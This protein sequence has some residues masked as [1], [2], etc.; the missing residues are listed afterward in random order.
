[1][2]GPAAEPVKPAVGKVPPESEAGFFS[3]LL[4][5]WVLPFIR[6]AWNDVQDGSFS[7]KSLP[8][9]PKEEA[10]KHNIAHL[11]KLWEQ[12]VKTKGANASL[13][14]AC[15]KLMGNTLLLC[16]AIM[17]CQAL[18][19]MSGPLLVGELIKAIQGQASVGVG[20]LMC[21]LLTL[22]TA[23]ASILQQGSWHMCSRSARQCWLALS[24]LIFEKPAL[25]SSAGRSDLTE[26]E[27]VNNMAV[28][29]QQVLQFM[30]FFAVFASAPMYLLVPTVIIPV[31]LGWPYFVGLSISAATSVA[32]DRIAI[33]VK[34]AQA[35]K[36]VAADK[37]NA[38]LNE[39]FQGIRTVKLNGWESLMEE[40]IEKERDAEMVALR[41]FHVWQSVQQAV[42]FGMPT[43]AVVVT[44]MLHAAQGGSFDA[45]TVFICVGLYEFLTLGTSIIPH[46]LNMLRQLRQNMQRMQKLLHKPDDFEPCNGHGL[47]PGTVV[48]EDA[49]FRWSAGKPGEAPTL[50]GM[51]LRVEPGEM[52][53]I[54]GRVGSGKSTWAG[55]LLGLVSRTRGST[56]VSGTVAYVTQ[57]AQIMND[58][59]RENI[60][61]GMPFD[62]DWYDRVIEACALGDDLKQCVA[63]DATEIG[64]RGITISG[65]QK[66]RIA[67][68]RA[69]YS[70]ADVMVFD[71]PLSAMDAHIGKVVFDRCFRTLLAGKTRVFFTNQLHFCAYCS[72]VVMLEDGVI[73]E[74]GPY[75]EL[76]SKSPKG[77]FGIFLESVVGGAT[78]EEGGDAPEAEAVAK[79]E[80]AKSAPEPTRPAK[81]ADDTPKEKGKDGKTMSV[82]KKIKGRIGVK[83]WMQIARAS[84]AA[85]LGGTLLIFCVIAPVAQYSVNIILAMWTDSLT[86]D[87]VVDPDAGAFE[88]PGPSIAYVG[89]AF[90]FGLILFVRGVLCVF[91]FLKSSRALH[92][93]MLAATV[94]QTM[95]WFDTTPVGRVLARFGNDVMFMDI[96]LPMLFQMWSLLF[97]R[98]IV[99]VVVA[100]ITAPPALLLSGFILLAAKVIYRYYGSLALELQ[101]VQMIALSPMLAAQSSFLSALDSVRCFGRVEIFVERFYAMQTNFIQT[102]YWSFT[103]DRAIQCIFTTMGVSV[104]FGATGC[105]LLFLSVYDTPLSGLVTPG[106]SGAIL[107]FCSILAFQAPVTLFMTARVEAM[108]ASVQRVAEYRDQP[109]E[110]SKQAIKEDVPASWPS[111]G[112]LSLDSVDMRYQESLPLALKCVSFDVAPGEKVGIVGRTGS[113]KSSIILTCFRMVDCCGGTLSIDGRD[114]SRVRLQELR[115]RLGVIPQDSWLFSGTIRQNLDMYGR[116]SDE[117][118]WNVLKIVQ[119]ESAAKAWPSG[120][121]HEVKEK[122]DNLSKGTAQL[123]CLARVLLKRPKLLFMDEAT[124]SVDAETDKLVQETIRKDGVLPHDCAI[125]TIAHRLHSVIDYDRIVVLAEGRVLEDAHP[126]ELLANDDGAF[127]KL[128]ESTDKA[129]SRELRRRS[130]VS[131]AAKSPKA[132]LQLPGATFEENE[133]VAK[134]PAKGLPVAAATPS[135]A[136]TKAAPSSKE[137]GCFVPTG[138]SKDGCFVSFN[139]GRLPY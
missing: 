109:T 137:C 17:S 58:T 92:R 133:E 30:Q 25:L 83:D 65:G 136:V 3:R 132:A 88:D 103:L 55:G 29:A 115:G 28:D 32:C 22:S 2:S 66:Q 85:F 73:A 126:A 135:K 50:L 12:E 53:A 110:D 56:S 77:P 35:K 87:G 134:R 99:I 113:G 94:R 112:L 60:L 104:F 40:R 95:T 117:E 123:L 46:M 79:P 44:F 34:D 52:V 119:L 70:R 118:I 23:A 61:F 18:L 114:I 63:G 59:I 107:A 62:Q 86:T 125:V 20:L 74:A 64:E 121:D 36:L 31:F 78:G 10:P 7:S 97:F 51:R 57:S 69:A 27:I 71:D 41:R 84:D 98:V 127:T 42:G 96:M 24:G 48:C 14:V 45:A 43:V 120:L 122:G 131:L 108:L 93:L 75:K 4:F 81:A 106:S 1:M 9:I 101:R 90:L 138:A 129:S 39:C 68:A 13:A 15:A 80:A 33:K 116:Y 124:A 6:S 26:G 130:Q 38:C 102:F 21:A 91:Y 89:A 72:H 11:R 5:L 67:V 82:E 37:R 76:A 100:G 111:K 49:D 128:V 105:L 54:C 47:P 16:F 139:T 8:P 19:L